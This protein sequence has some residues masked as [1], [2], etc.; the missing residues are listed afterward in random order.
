MKH[1]I[2]IP[3]DFSD[4]AWNAI[5]YALRLYANEECAFYFLHS[6][7]VKSTMK[8]YITTHYMDD[9]KEDS[10]K[11][12]AEL[13]DMA[14]NANINA[15]HSFEIILVKG[16]LKTAI[17]STV[18]KHNIDLVVM[19]T[20][21]ATGAKEIFF[22]S[23]TVDIIKKLMLCPI[24]VVPEE[25]DFVEPK[26]VAFPTDFNRF[27][28]EE[29]LPI[30]RLSELYDSKIRIV[31]IS[32][33]NNLTKIQDY[34]FAMLQVYLENHPHSFHWMPDYAKKTQEIN[35]F[36]EELDIDILAMINYKHSFIEKIVNEPVV[37]KIGFHSKIPFLVIPCSI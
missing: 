23:N 20:K 27:Y 7:A 31:H 1:S 26:H 8:S 4:N 34:N 15:N 37:N 33:K 14:E 25:F 11:E 6:W 13:K 36:N 16:K 17:E 5:V 18:K 10:L 24:L 32:E 21:G 9:L 29:L 3:T 30:K 12:L 2:L 28:G 22:G 19:G 35:D